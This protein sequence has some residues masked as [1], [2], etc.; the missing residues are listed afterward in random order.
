M[1]FVLVFFADELIPMSTIH[2]IK[3]SIKNPDYSPLH[4]YGITP[5]LTELVR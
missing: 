1:G 5:R 2:D 4:K 3:C